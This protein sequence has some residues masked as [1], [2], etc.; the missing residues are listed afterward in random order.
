MNQIVPSTGDNR[1]IFDPT[2]KIGESRYGGKCLHDLDDI[3]TVRSN[4]GDV[5]TMCSEC[6]ADPFRR[7][8]A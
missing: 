2:R 7:E 6:G 3:V 5:A 4:D 8:S 1:N